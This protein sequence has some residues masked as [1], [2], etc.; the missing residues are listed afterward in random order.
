M[1]AFWEYPIPNPPL[2]HDYPKQ[3][4]TYQFPFIPSQNK[5]KSQLQI[6]KRTAKNWS[7]EKKIVVTPVKNE[8]I[9]Q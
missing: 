8:C 1:H 6:K 4:S 2:T 9:I 5:T 3:P 7:V